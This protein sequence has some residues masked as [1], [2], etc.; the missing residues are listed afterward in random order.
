MIQLH[1]KVIEVCKEMLLQ[2]GFTDIKHDTHGQLLIGKKGLLLGSTPSQG[3]GSTPPLGI[4]LNTVDKL[5]VDKIKEYIGRAKKLELVHCILIYT[6]N[7]TPVAS[8]I[9]RKSQDIEFEIFKETELMF[10]L[11]KHSLVPLHEKLSENDSLPFKNLQIPSLLSTDCVSRFLGFRSG[12]VIKITR[13]D[14]FISY[15]VV[16]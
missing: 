16:K 5:N 3:L 7:V 12:D 2:R 8:K 1:E 11:T 10:N 6:G 9:I 14:S 4:F 15:R 13:K